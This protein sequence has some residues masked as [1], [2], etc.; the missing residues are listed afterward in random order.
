MELSPKKTR[1]LLAC[2]EKAYTRL[3]AILSDHEITFVST[4]ADAEAT[5]K[6]DDFNLI[7][8]GTRFDGSRIFD[9]LRSVKRDARHSGLPVICFRGIKLTETKDKSLLRTV[10]MA[11]K[12][13]GANSFFDLLAFA[14]DRLGNAGVRSIV[15]HLI[16]R[17]QNKSQ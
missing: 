15:N 10:E 13:M 17:A 11:C 4:L 16:E 3:Y 5:L 6:G 9:L 8:I 12:E 14:D 7:M 2:A 1:I